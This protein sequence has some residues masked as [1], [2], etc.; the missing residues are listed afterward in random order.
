[1]LDEEIDH[2][3]EKYRSP[4]VLCYLQGH[5]TEEAAKLLG[6]PERTIQFR[7][8]R[9][10]EQLRSR[11]TR[12]GLALSAGWL[13]THLS[14]NVSPAAVPTVLVD[15]TVKAA[16]EFAAGQA[17]GGLVSSSVAALTQGVLR[18]M[19]ISK[20]KKTAVV[21]ITVAALAMRPGRLLKWAFG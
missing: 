3:P 20:L 10:R 2:L 12:R 1:M 15:S 21:M 8:S 7:L 5:S 11:F 19:F 9:G 16:M 13:A 14:M 4:I 6:C 17:V 18:A